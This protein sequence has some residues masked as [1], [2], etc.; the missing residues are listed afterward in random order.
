MD[1]PATSVTATLRLTDIVKSFPGVRALRGVSFEVLAGEVHA[2]LGENGAGKSTLMA[3]AAGATAP[4][5]GTVEIGGHRLEHASPAAA[6]ALGLSVVYQH[7]SVLDDLTV[8]ENLLLAVPGSRR[9]PQRQVERWTADHLAVVGADLPPRARAGELGVAERQLL[10]IAR[11]LALESKVLVL[12]EPTESLTETESHRLFEQIDAVR[13]RGASVVYISHRLPEVRRVADRVTI[14]RD[15]EVRGTFAAA[16][17]DDAE[18]LRLIVG[19]PVQQTFPPKRRRQACGDATP[20]PVLEVSGLRGPRL[21]GAG[22]TVEPGEIVGLAGVEGNGQREV[23]RALAG[24]IPHRGEVRVGGVAADTRTPGRARR[25]GILYL[26]RD[27]H[28]EGLLG[29]LSV[30]ENISLLVLRELA[31]R[32]FVAR[33]QEAELARRQSAAFAIKAA[34][35]ESPVSTLS[36]GN[37]QKVVLARTLAAEPSVLLA[38]EPT[39]GVDVGAR[40]EIYR[41]LRQAADAGR[42]VVVASADVLELQ[43]LCDKV[44]VFSRG[45]VVETLAGE[46]VTEARMTGAAITAAV[47]RGAEGP[48]SRRRAPAGGRERPRREAPA[49]RA[50]RSDLAPSS[51]LGLIIVAL[52]LATGSGHPLFFSVRDLTS[53]LFLASAAILVSLG[54]LVVL[55]GASFDLSVGPLMGLTVVV[56][57]F[58]ATSGRGYGGL[59][60][61]ILVA[62]GVGVAVGVT[63]AVLIRVLRIGPVISTLVTYIALQGVSLLLRP[64]PAGSLSFT[65]TGGIETSFGPVP[66]V[67]IVVVAL[68]L[69]GEVWLKRSHAGRELRAVGSDEVRAY[70]VGARVEWTLLGAQVACSL[71]AVAAGVLLAA[72]VGIGDPTLGTDYTLTSLAAAVLGGASIFGGRGS[73]VG[74]LLGALL[75]QEIVTATSFLGLPQAWTE[76]LPGALILL[77]AGAYS[78]LRAARS[79]RLGAAGAS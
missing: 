45:Q 29:S 36:G 65:V 17:I 6:Q 27:R 72:E 57:S 4:D 61:G 77:G 22:V 28:R 48:D 60:V 39:R 40:M 8:A 71:L 67:F 52:A 58:F 5:S 7:P 46:E 50:A 41:L 16:E 13:R 74:A 11:A 69:T 25:S 59:A 49:W 2:L 43:G 75:L 18:V 10:E 35:T 9:P 34:T 32:G 42:A 24:L 26:P 19:R 23:L 78:R 54:Q 20:P 37:Q 1:L 33:R 14:L 51:V 15:G 21:S 66:L 64:Q 31:S 63:N 79:A 55:L 73:F 62:V 76:W 38:D 70:R 30:R 68:T 12:D 56:L 47:S 53:V 44:Y 3:V